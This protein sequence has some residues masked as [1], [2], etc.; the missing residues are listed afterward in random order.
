MASMP[1]IN[2]PLVRQILLID[3]NSAKM[4]LY[5]VNEVHFHTA[6]TL[7]AALFASAK[8][9]ILWNSWARFFKSVKVNLGLGASRP[10]LWQ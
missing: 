3:L 8:T 9:N 2:I 6:T 1:I 4:L 10:K 7:L 5:G